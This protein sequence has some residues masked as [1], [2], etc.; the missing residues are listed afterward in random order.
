MP[1]LGNFL[2][3]LGGLLHGAM[4]L[5]GEEEHLALLCEFS[6]AMFRCTAASRVHVGEWVVENEEAFHAVEIQFGES[7]PGS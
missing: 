6:E 1:R 3:V 5:A 7:Q 4:A 2:W